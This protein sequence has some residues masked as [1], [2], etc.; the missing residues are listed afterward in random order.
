MVVFPLGRVS[1]VEFMVSRADEINV[2]FFRDFI[3]ELSTWFRGVVDGL[4]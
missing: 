3:C 2:L 4:T 1:F